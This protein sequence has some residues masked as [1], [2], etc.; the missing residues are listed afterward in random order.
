MPFIWLR[1]RVCTLVPEGTKEGT[2][3]INL[4]PETHFSGFRGQICP[5]HYL[6]GFVIAMQLR[7]FW[8]KSAVVLLSENTFMQ[9]SKQKRY[10][11]LFVFIPASCSLSVFAINFFLLCNFIFFDKTNRSRSIYLFNQ[12]KKLMQVTGNLISLML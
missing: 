7:Q 6:T 9:K 5:R 8:R 1:Q 10:D 2:N 4:S 12:T 3:L 11:E